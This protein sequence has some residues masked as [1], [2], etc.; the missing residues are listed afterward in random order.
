MVEGGAAAAPGSDPIA[1]IRRALMDSKT[2]LST[3]NSVLTGFKCGLDRLEGQMMPIYNLTEKLRETQ[4]NID[5]SVHELR[6]VNETFA[7]AT[8]VAPTLHQGAK[9]DQAEYFKAMHRLLESIS[10][11]ESHRGYEGCGKALEQARHVLN[12]AQVKCKSDIVNDIGLFCRY[13]MTS[14]VS[15]DPDDNDPSIDQGKA[16]H[17]PVVTAS[18]PS[19]ADVAKVNA[20]VQCLLGTG[21]VPRQLL[22]EYGEK[23]L[24][25][26]KDF[27]KDA[28]PATPPADIS[29]AQHMKESIGRYLDMVVYVIK[30]EKG[31][32][33]KVFATED[34]SHAALSYTIAPLLETLT[35]DVKRGTPHRNDV[36]RPLDLHYLFKAKS[37]AF[38]DALQP[39][40]RLREHPG[41]E[42]AD[43]WKLVGIVAKMEDELAVAAK[44]TLSQFKSDIGDALMQDKQLGR[45]RDGN[46]HPVS[47]NVMQFVRHLCDH[48][49]ELEC[50]LKSDQTTNVAYFVDSIVMKLIESLKA[51]NVIKGGREDLRTLFTLNNVMYISQSLKQLGQDLHTP[52]QAVVTA[53]LQQTIQPKVAALGDKA[54]QDFMHLSYDEFDA[55]LADPTTK[56]QY[57]RNSDVLT[58]DSGRL[59]KEKFTKFNATLDEVVANQKSYTVPDADLRKTLMASALQRIVPS[60]TI[61]YDKYS[62]VHF[63]KKHMDKY[64]KYTPANVDAMLRELFQG[65]HH[66]STSSHTSSSHTSSS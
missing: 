60:Y 31:L 29:T 28:N 66:P 21:L 55:I 1:V 35:H 54:I 65:L 8:E 11:M 50:L 26:I 24:K 57:N 32:A 53:A 27:F 5:L 15:S 63:S 44:S 42:T 49:V 13:A 46:V 52:A 40:L 19:D 58:L 6:A 12:L 48:V 41:V 56:L 34:L 25:H 43:P 38:Q 51:S 18:Q 36:F 37:A 62:V 14:P 7:T 33:T 17:E 22:V 23:R 9:Y 30:V 45:F 16:Q 47:S 3:V 10:F 59:V 20:L 2:Q 39:P 64:V 4:K 61:F